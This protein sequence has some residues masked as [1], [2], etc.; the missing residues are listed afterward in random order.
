MN[1][2]NL[3]ATMRRRWWAAGAVLAAVM[4]TG[5]HAASEPPQFAVT[6]SL[7]LR[8]GPGANGPLVG[9][10]HNLLT[11]AQTLALTLVSDGVGGRLG[12]RRD[13]VLY[14]MTL[15]QMGANLQH[16]GPNF[17][18]ILELATM[19][20]T[21]ERTTQAMDALIND[22]QSALRS[23]QGAVPR[24]AL[25]NAITIT[26]SAHPLPLRGSKKRALAALM[27]LAGGA[28]AGAAVVVD[29]LPMRLRR[30]GRA[31]HA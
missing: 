1:V 6:A 25:I 17:G 30:K 15:E 23:R 13:G 21:A 14:Q 2:W 31:F 4:F 22:T 18:P 3:L 26:K 24:A 10:D 19:G 29:A 12:I 7:L 9:N 5:M 8:V 11:T 27:L 20:P 28:A 16:G